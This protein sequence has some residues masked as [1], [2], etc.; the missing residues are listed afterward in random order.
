MILPTV[1]AGAIHDRQEPTAY[2]T[3][4]LNAG[5]KCPGDVSHRKFSTSIRSSIEESIRE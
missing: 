2:P 5:E 4:N 3:V 1:S